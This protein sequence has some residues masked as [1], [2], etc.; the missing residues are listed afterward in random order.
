MK[1]VIKRRAIAA[2]VVL[3]FEII[4]DGHTLRMKRLRLVYQYLKEKYKLLAMRKYTTIAG[5]LVFFLLMSIV[6]LAF[7]L[8]L[9]VGKL[10]INVE[11]VLSLSVFGS[12]REVLVYVQNEAKNATAGA[13][14]LLLF[15][16]LYS[17]T[18]LFYQM[19]RSGELIYDH[20]P[21]HQ[22]WRLRVGALLLLIVVMATVV[23]F[24]SVFALGS[25][26]FSRALPRG[27][28]LVADYF[29]LAAVSFFLIFVLNMYVCPYKV[30]VRCFIPGTVLTVVAWIVAIVGFSVYLKIGN[31]GKLY[32]AFSAIIIFLLWLYALMICFIVGVIFNS[33]RVLKEYKSTMKFAQK[34]KSLV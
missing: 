16:T 19:K 6:P 18:N 27:W 26:L 21:E 22:G 11:D 12:V 23:V 5:T 13:S 3:T 32:G 8:T 29:L 7:W 15:T 28:G 20:R 34:R 10:P 14:F 9:I 2:F 30:K 1:N 25:F 4:K 17:A 33:E 24:L 31:V